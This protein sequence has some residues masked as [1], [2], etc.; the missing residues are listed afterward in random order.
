MRQIADNLLNCNGFQR[1]SAQG[2]AFLV[3]TLKIARWCIQQEE[4]IESNEYYERTYRMHFRS[5]RRTHLA[6]GDTQKNRGKGENFIWKF[7]F[8]VETSECFFEKN[9]RQIS[10]IWSDQNKCLWFS[11][12][13]PQ[14]NRWADLPELGISS[15]NLR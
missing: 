4:Y 6:Y 8:G 7:I 14:L 10:K 1:Q 3:F 15:N 11:L 13:K 5:R 9:K 12:Y 2:C